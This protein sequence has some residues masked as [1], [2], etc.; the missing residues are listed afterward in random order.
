M[1]QYILVVKGSLLKN[2][3]KKPHIVFKIH[4]KQQKQNISIIYSC[5]AKQYFVPYSESFLFGFTPAALY[6]FGPTL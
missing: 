6:C 3:A 4:V 5:V 1:K 2:R